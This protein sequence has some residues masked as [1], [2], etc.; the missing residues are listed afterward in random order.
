MKALLTSDTH[1]GFSQKTHIIH[2]RFLKNLAEVIRLNDVKFIIHAGDWA[3]NKQDQFERT[4]IM[5]RK[6]IHI[7]ILSV[8]G[9]HE[10]WDFN[11]DSKSKTMWGELD[12]NHK[13]WFKAAGI[14]HLEADG[15]FTIGDTI[16]V[17]FDGWYHQLN[18]P[19]NDHEQMVGYIEGGTA[20]QYH[21]RRA[22]KALEVVLQV[23][24]S[25]Y[26]TAICVTH[27]P[28]T[29]NSIVDAA[30]NGNP[31]YFDF[32]KDKFDIL[33]MGHSHR[34]VNEVR[35]G[36]RLLNC[37]SDYDK[38]NFILFETDTKGETNEGS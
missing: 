6:Y 24:R 20:H 15:P 13:A 3:C 4:L 36:V 34:F 31:M 11:K 28:V 25:Q 38:P 21:N 14:H 12:K 27:M 37:G 32:I 29:V 8:R 2:E 7:P 30:F 19:T 26:N 16:I 35:D 33:C 18:P 9:N 5:F 1:Y 22:H 17:G 23:D 10:H